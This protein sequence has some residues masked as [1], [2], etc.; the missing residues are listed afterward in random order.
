MYSDALRT[1]VTE[2]LADLCADGMCPEALSEELSV[3][4]THQ[5]HLLLTASYAVPSCAL[6]ISANHI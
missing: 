4:I 5:C 2:M 6:N 1:E 3:L